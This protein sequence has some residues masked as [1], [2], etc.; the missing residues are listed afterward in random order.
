MDELEDLVRSLAEPLLERHGAELVEL[1]V[2][3]GRTQLIRIVADTPSGIDLDTCASVSRELSRMLDVD[4]PIPG[5]YTLEV[6]S[7][8]LDRP[9]RAPRD[10]ERNR[11]RLVRIVLAQGQ[12]EGT[13]EEVGQ[14][15]VTVERDGERTVVPLD[16]IAKA[17]LILP[18]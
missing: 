6:T 7:P 2:L 10:F 15:S 14:D 17:K 3:R 11:G 4:D 16:Q 12:H 1:S 8:G 9:L 18:W 5:H 13:I